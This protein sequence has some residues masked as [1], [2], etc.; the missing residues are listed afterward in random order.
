MAA[1]SSTR[2]RILLLLLV[3]AAGG[4]FALRWWAHHLA[5]TQDRTYIPQ[6]PAFT[7]EVR[8]LQEYVRIDTTNPPGNESAGARF[9]AGLLAKGGASYE[10]IEPKPGRGSLYSRIRGRQ[11]GGGLLLLH[12][13]DVVPAPPAGWKLPPFSG[14]IGGDEL[15]G[16]GSLDMKGVGICELAAYL[17]VVRSG[18]Q[19]EHDIVFLAVADEEEGGALGTGWLIEHR[20]DIFEGIAYVLNEG[21]VTET[22]LQKVRYV[23]IEIGSKTEVITT[24]H[25][26]ALEQLQAARIALEPYFGNDEPDRVLPEV[27]QYLHEVAA[28]RR[29]QRERLEDVQKTIAEGKFWL[30]Q[31]PYRELMQS[32]VFCSSIDPAPPG[33][34][35]KTYLMMLPGDHPD[36]RIAW[37]TSLVKPFGVTVEI[38]RRNEPTPLSS[39]NTPVFRIL[40]GAF[41]QIY[42]VPVGSYILTR[43][44]NDCRYLRPKGMQ[45]YGL[46]PYAV[47]YFESASIHAVNERLRIPWFQDGVTVIR[48]VVARYAGLPDPA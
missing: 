21:G 15:Y 10:I 46:A 24:L 17:D 33:Y 30:L 13:I 29:E 1:A 47:D 31:R 19:P 9:L 7:P 34:A 2:T 45:C 32:I 18:K 40:Q 48:R 23:G 43:S 12:H 37:L 26:P 25:A 14:E 6:E 8:L 11:R 20:P 3:V 38:V 16:R 27:R 44:Y 5:V 39:E 22:E 4:A 36:E 35:M 41:G 42:Q 28:N